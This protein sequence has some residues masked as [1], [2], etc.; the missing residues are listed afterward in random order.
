MSL[1]FAKSAEKAFKNA[2][3]Q[4][5]NNSNTYV[6][7]EHLVYAI[8]QLDGTAVSKLLSK[9]ERRNVLAM[10]EN[11]LNNLPKISP[12]PEMVNPSQ[13]LSYLITSAENEGY[14]SADQLLY[15]ALDL[16]RI[17]KIF[18]TGFREKLEKAMIKNLILTMLIMLKKKQVN[19]QLSWLNKQEK[20]Y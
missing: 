10:L 20:V 14:I 11:E 13:I 19:L 4:A 16:D 15:Q 3:Q 9:E 6:E 2:Q 1:K 7:P 18:P 8:I 5:K 17:K 12:K